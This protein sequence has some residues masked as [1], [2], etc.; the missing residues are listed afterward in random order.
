[1]NIEIVK[2]SVSKV[3]NLT[4]RERSRRDLWLVF[5]YSNPQ[6]TIRTILR[7][8]SMKTSKSD[9]T[10]DITHFKENGSFT[11]LGESNKASNYLGDTLAGK[12][13]I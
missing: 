10:A 1:M 9:I 7:H 4:T 8:S 6:N 3:I 13:T 12:F 2:R 5:F 11:R